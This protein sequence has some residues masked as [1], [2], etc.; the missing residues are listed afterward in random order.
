MSLDGDDTSLPLRLCS[1]WA[2]GTGGK[3]SL[4]VRSRDFESRAAKFAQ[5]LQIFEKRALALCATLLGLSPQEASTTYPQRFVQ[6]DPSEALASVLLLFQSG[7]VERM[8]PEGVVEVLRQGVN[9]AITL[10]PAQLDAITAELRAAPI[11][12]PAQGA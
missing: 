1:L 9:A 3:R 4:R 2:A 11:A 7:L 8:G 5:N 12:P 10:D 6:R